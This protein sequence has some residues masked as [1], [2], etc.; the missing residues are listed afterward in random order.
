[1]ARRRRRKGSAGVSLARARARGFL[2][3]AREQ[4]TRSARPRRQ[5]PEGRP[6]SHSELRRTI[7]SRTCDRARLCMAEVYSAM[8]EEGKMLI[9]VDGPRLVGPTEDLLPNDVELALDLGEV[10]ASHSKTAGPVDW[11]WRRRRLRSF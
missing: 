3:A 4:A 2:V 8:M 1:V 6:L 9:V 11:Q 7:G 10:S 5:Q